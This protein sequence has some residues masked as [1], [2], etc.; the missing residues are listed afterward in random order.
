VAVNVFSAQTV[1][2]FVEIPVF[3]T[4]TRSIMKNLS[5]LL[6]ALIGMGLV[7]QAQVFRNDVGVATRSF[8]V[9]HFTSMNVD[10]AFRVELT[11]QSGSSSAVKVETDENQLHRVEVE[12]RNEVLFVKLRNSLRNPKRLILYVTTDQYKRIKLQGANALNSTTP[13]RGDA[14][15][16]DF[17]GASEV[18]LTLDFD[19]VRADIAGSCSLALHGKA[20]QASLSV[21]GVGNLSAQDLEVNQVE[22]RVSG[23]GSADVYA[24]ETLVAEVSGMGNV[25]YRGDPTVQQSVSGMG[26]IKRN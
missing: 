23:T 19:R 12:V 1:F 8:E 10:G 25:T 26:S 22:V 14:I 16:L 9:A 21:S 20:N 3:H 15:E 2:T 24:Q 18:D 6:I 7:S 4:L 17:S 5:L 11:Q 13:L